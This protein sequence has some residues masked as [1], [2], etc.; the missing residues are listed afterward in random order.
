MKSFY[1]DHHGDVDETAV[2]ELKDDF[3][4]EEER[5]FLIQIYKKNLHIGLNIHRKDRVSQYDIRRENSYIDQKDEMKI[6]P[7]SEEAEVQY[8]VLTSGDKKTIP[9]IVSKIQKYLGGPK[10]R[11][12]FFF[13]PK[14]WV[15]ARHSEMRSPSLNICLL[16]GGTEILFFNET[17]KV[18]Q[19]HKF[20]GGLR[21]AVLY[22]TARWHM[23]KNDIDQDRLVLSANLNTDVGYNTLSN[24]FS[25]RIKDI[26]CDS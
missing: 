4:T 26:I 2:V 5:L 1:G 15:S 17:G 23:I 20:D 13:S 11:L 24:K 7:A 6:V 12:G 3:I 22:N 10:L 19:S 25:D 21:K 8:V 14:H 16:D 9:S 18:V